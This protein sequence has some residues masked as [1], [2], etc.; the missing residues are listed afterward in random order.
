MGDL[1][2][3]TS[4]VSAIKLGSSTVTKIYQGTN[5]IYSISNPPS[6]V[7]GLTLNVLSNTEIHISYNAA[8]DD[9]TVVGYWIQSSTTSSTAGFSTVID[10]TPGLTY[11]DTGLPN[12]T[13]HWYR[14][15]AKD[16]D[17]Q[18]STNWSSVATATTQTIIPP[19][20]TNCSVSTVSSSRIDVSWTNVTPNPGLTIVGYWIQKSS[21]S[22]SSGFT[23]VVDTTINNPYQSIGL[24]PDTQYWYRVKAKN[25]QGEYSTNWS[26]VDSD[27]T[28]I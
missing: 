3:G 8:T 2:F 17:G 12:N 16:N 7:F 21:T 13:Q 20:V 11:N 26:N 10:T 9:G 27:F 15:K 4:S 19:D 25:D 18:Y 22:S 1:K 6:I 28:D 14:V 23:T 5:V 24:D